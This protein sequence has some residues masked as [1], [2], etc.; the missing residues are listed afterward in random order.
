MSGLRSPCVPHQISAP[1][2]PR[3]R[4]AGRNTNPLDGARVA[5]SSLLDRY[6]ITIRNG[7]K[8]RSVVDSDVNMLH[9]VV[10]HVHVFH[11]SANAW[12][13][14]TWSRIGMLL[15]RRMHRPQTKRHTNPIAE[16]TGFD[17][18]KRN[19][20]SETPKQ[21]YSSMGLAIPHARFG[22]AFPLPV[23]PTSSGSRLDFPLLSPSF[24]SFLDDADGRDL[25]HMT[26]VRPRRTC[27]T[28]F[29]G[30]TM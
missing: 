23:M 20:T 19:A 16:K 9:T 8:V 27:T 24:S 10:F 1:E 21:Q 7:R 11:G 3:H 6:G 2:R 5:S 28:I 30:P 14:R 18:L 22:W 13:Q 26:S 29:N 15:A 17:G 25:L 12:A 4:K